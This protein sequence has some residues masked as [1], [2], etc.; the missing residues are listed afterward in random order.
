MTAPD[1]VLSGAKEFHCLIILHDTGVLSELAV[2]GQLL[3]SVGICSGAVDQHCGTQFVQIEVH[4]PLPVDV[5][6]SSAAHLMA[7]HH[8][9][10][11]V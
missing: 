10:G 2:K 7:S 8:Q 1:A 6:G 4:I 11:V 5:V 9:V 3:S